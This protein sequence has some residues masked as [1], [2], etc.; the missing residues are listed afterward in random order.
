MARVAVVG[1]VVV[2]VSAWALTEFGGTALSPGAIKLA[3]RHL[4]D[5][6]LPPDERRWREGA[7][8]LE[9]GEV[10]RAAEVLNAAHGGT[11]AVFE[12]WARRARLAT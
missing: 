12:W 1:L 6:P 11:D 9:R 2:L 10:A 5:I 8:L 3:A 7:I 4:R